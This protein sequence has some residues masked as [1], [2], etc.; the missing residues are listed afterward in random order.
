VKSGQK[1]VENPKSGQEVAKQRFLNLKSSF[2]NP[3][4]TIENIE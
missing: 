1:G 3:L 4:K 2:G